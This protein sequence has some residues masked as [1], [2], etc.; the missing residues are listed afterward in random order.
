MWG[1]FG[2]LLIIPLCL[3]ALSPLLAYRDATYITAAMAGIAALTLFVVQPVFAAGF[4]PGV[5]RL[6]LKHW[7]RW[8][9]AAIVSLVAIH[10]GGLYITSPA[11]ALDALLLVSPTWF[12]VYGVIGMWGI[13][14]T[15][16]L[17]A[18]KSRLKLPYPRWQIL[19]NSLMIVVVISSVVHALQIEGTMDT[20]SKILLCIAVLAAAGAAFIHMWIVPPGRRNRRVS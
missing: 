8:I 20:F 5:S 10:I 19:H 16:V 18:L 17:V 1:A 4:V 9:G 15:I 2:L 7:H 3:A 13:I 6:R 12:S 14:I 11:D